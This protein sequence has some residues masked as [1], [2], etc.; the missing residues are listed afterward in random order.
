MKYLLAALIAV[1]LMGGVSIAS[2]TTYHYD[3]VTQDQDNEM[4]KPN[5]DTEMAIKK[6]PS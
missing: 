4:K 6:S 2:C 1:G 5:Q 3:K